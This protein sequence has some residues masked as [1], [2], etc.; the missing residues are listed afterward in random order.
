VS[1]QEQKEKAKVLLRSEKFSDALP[2]F[3]TIWDQE[4]NEWN[5][6]YLAQCLRKVEAFEEAVDLHLELTQNYPYSKPLLHE[7]LWLDYKTKLSR[8]TNADFLDSAETILQHASQHDKF[9]KN[10]FIKTILRVARQFF[11]G[12]GDL[13]QTWLDRMDQSLLGN[14][15]FRFNNIVYPA[16][17]KRYFI[18]YA[19]ALINQNSHI[20]YLEEQLAKL[21]FKGIK[22]TAFL[23]FMSESFT[24]K[25][26]NETVIARTR[27]ALYIK[28]LVD[29]LHLRK[30]T[31]ITPSYKE[32]KRT[33]VSDL[34]HFLFCPVSYAIHQTYEVYAQTSWERD[35]WKQDKL[36]LGDRLRIYKETGILSKAFA[37][38][39]INFTEELK[40]QIHFIFQSELIVDNATS[41]EPTIFNS[42]EGTLTGAPDYILKHPTGG[43]FVII[44][45]F[46]HISSRDKEQPYESDLI[47]PLAFLN[48]FGSIGLRF[49]LIL[50]WYWD[51]I[52]IPSEDKIR[53]KI[54][55]RSLKVHR[56]DAG[57]HELKLQTAIKAVEN[58]R[59]TSELITD[60]DKLSWPAKCLN[61]SVVSYCHH[62]TGRFD[63]IPLPY[64]LI[65]P[66]K[67][68]NNRLLE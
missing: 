14:N 36:Y 51:L 34:S 21:H 39:E 1:L 32:I 6:Y 67:N 28:N 62:K 41:S 3:Q 4:K 53:K 30:R 61:C 35:E 46:S 55:L 33:L 19:D 59:K 45:K 15:V 5:G 20:D 11:P 48:K 49:G 57:H 23:R 25:W 22:H 60:G 52:D 31:D 43:T 38:A 54:V 13:K 56:M 12:E 44:E 40:K 18:E 37:D 65:A 8:W 27:L 68:D 29:E 66:I 16:D 42:D 9:T 2:I 58:F 47:K 24:F 64:T 63:Q 50:N 7:K 10:L 26:D 17:R